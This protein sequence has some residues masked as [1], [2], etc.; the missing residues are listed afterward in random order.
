[1]L[2]SMYVGVFIDVI[3]YIYSCCQ[4]DGV[5]PENDGKEEEEETKINEESDPFLAHMLLSNQ[6]VNGE[7]PYDVNKVDPASF[8]AARKP[9]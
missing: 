5:E 3:I 1:M 6:F 7:P 8:E 4:I 9:I 2:V